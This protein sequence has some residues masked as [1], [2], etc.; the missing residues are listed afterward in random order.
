MHSYHLLKVDFNKAKVRYF[1]HGQEDISNEPELLG[2]KNG[3][4]RKLL[5][6][7]HDKLFY[8]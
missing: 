5:Y 8:P 1:G 2:E 3:K 6:P 4:I 7:F